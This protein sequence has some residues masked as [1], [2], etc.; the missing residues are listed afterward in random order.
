VCAG[1]IYAHV[2]RRAGSPRPLR[3]LVSLGLAKVFTDQAVPTGGLGGSV[4]VVR[5]LERRG[6]DASTAAAAV[7]VDLLVHDVVFL[8]LLGLALAFLRLRHDLSPVVL[9]A[10]GLF[11]VV[12]LTVP[13]LALG[14]NARGVD[15]VPGWVVR[16]PAV[17]EVVRAIAAVPHGVLRDARLLGG[18]ALLELGIFALDGLTLAMMLEAVGATARPT[19]VFAAYTVAYLAGAVGIVPG[20]LGTFEAGCVA[21]LTLLGV[22]VEAALTATLLLRLLTFWAPM[23]PGALAARRELAA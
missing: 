12:A 21:T 7:V 14:V 2:L 13:G 19:T 20:G 18:V 17:G 16:L 10:A 23:V 4:V 6:Q 11:L 1:E 8:L 3:D 9:A 22:G 5:G 15:R